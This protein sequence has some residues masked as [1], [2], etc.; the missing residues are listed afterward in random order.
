MFQPLLKI[1][2]KEDFV[3]PVELAFTPETV[4]FPLTRI[5]IYLIEPVSAISTSL[6]L[7]EL[8]FVYVSVIVV[9]FPFSVGLG[10]KPASS[11]L[12][13]VVVF[14]GFKVIDALSTG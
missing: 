8:S 7:H 3:I 4:V 9:S 14:D 13:Y 10:C 1:T 2:F 12:F 5:L 11:V 6:S